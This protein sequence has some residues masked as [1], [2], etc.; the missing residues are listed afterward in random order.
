LQNILLS[1]QKNEENSRLKKERKKLLFCKYIFSKY[2]LQ[3][4][5]IYIIMVSYLSAKA[6]I[7]DLE[8]KYP[9]NGANDK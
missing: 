5:I 2:E 6:F 9:S 8:V 1:Y 3:E 7:S 4:R